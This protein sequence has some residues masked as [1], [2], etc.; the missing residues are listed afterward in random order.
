MKCV[1]SIKESNLNAKK[2]AK[3]SNM[4]TVRTDGADPTP[5]A[6]LTVSLI[7]EYPFYT[8]SQ[9]VTSWFLSLCPSEVN[10][11]TALTI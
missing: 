3:F 2:G 9:K 7:V 10:F 11:D 8:T 4:L 5:S 6:L 1:M